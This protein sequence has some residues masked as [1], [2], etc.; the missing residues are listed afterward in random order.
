LISKE[1]INEWLEEIQTRPSSAQH[2]VKIIGMRLQELTAQNEAL[3]E[4]NIALRTGNQVEEY[5][6]QIAHLG[7]QLELLKR[8]FNRRLSQVELDAVLDQTDRN[9]DRDIFP[10]GSKYCILVYGENGRILSLKLD[11]EKIHDGMIIGRIED[12]QNI[13]NAHPRMLVVPVTEELIWLFSSGRVATLPVA[14]LINIEEESENDNLLQS[15]KNHEPLAGEEL[16]CLAPIAQIAMSDF[17]VQVSRRAAFKKI[18]ISMLDTILSK[19]YIGSGVRSK[20]DRSF[21]LNLTQKDDYLITISWQGYLKSLSIADAQVSVDRLMTL[22][23]R[24]YLVATFVCKF[25]QPLMVVTPSGKII[26][27]VIDDEMKEKTG[28]SKGYALLSTKR[29]EMGVKV[30]G[31]AAVQENTK[32]MLTLDLKGII[33]AYD[34]GKIGA[35]GLV[36]TDTELIA[37]DLVLE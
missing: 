23:E 34:I 21:S 36:D 32:W 31:A 25:K 8:Q 30:I 17:I 37:F 5:K 19:R 27:R 28:K 9:N 7:Y 2:I 1:Q 4:E 20:V 33:R 24:D 6:R 22:D 15:R 14:S 11:Q 3:L 35:S 10:L 29:R 18:D 13:Q 16:V 26:S 12:S